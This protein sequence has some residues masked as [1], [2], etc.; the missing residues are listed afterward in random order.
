M[1][2]LPQEIYNEIGACFADAEENPRYVLSSPRPALATI[3]R[4]WQQAIEKQTFR[5]LRLRST[6]LDRFE[7]TVTGSRRRFLSGIRFVIILP[8]YPAE[9]RGR[10]ER[11]EERDA[12]D[13]AFTDAVNGLFRILKS[14]DEGKDGLDSGYSIQLDIEAVYS[15]TDDFHNGHNGCRGTPRRI[16]RIDVAELENDDEIRRRDLQ[17]RRFQ[18]SYI[19]LLGPAELPVVRA[20]SGFNTTVIKRRLAHRTAVDIAAKLPN[21]R[22]GNW[23]MDDSE[24]RYPAMR[25]SGRHQLAEV[26]RDV[27][28]AAEA[29]QTLHVCMSQDLLWNHAWLPADLT[30][31][32]K[33]A[34]GQE[35]S[36]QGSFDPLGCAIR[37]ATADL[38]S[39]KNLTVTGCLDESLL[40]PSPSSGPRL[41]EPF[42]QRLQRLDVQFNMTTPS[43]GW[44]FCARRPGDNIEPPLAARST[45]LLPPGHGYSEDEDTVAA[46]RYSDSENQRLSGASM[47]LFRWVPDEESLVPLVEAFGRA[48][49]QMPSLKVASLMTMIHVSLEVGAGRQVPTR[50][51]WGVSYA[52]PGEV[53]PQQFQLDPA[54]RENGGQRRVLWDV[55]DWQPP[56]HLRSILGDIGR[57][58]YG[59][60]LSEKHVDF[61]AAVMKPREL[62]R[63]RC[64]Y[65]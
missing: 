34:S 52:V 17:D 44:Y 19:R 61:W 55:K 46:L 33:E 60:E 37:E 38:G 10:F 11:K 59:D 7:K 64:S 27:L 24:Q 41:A 62:S 13:K 23:F 22:S 5:R 39:L 57:E 8:G 65:W 45:S 42:W 20:I 26:V 6:D 3:S 35:T 43:G 28:P 30:V 50:S 16:E 32:G 40:W 56:G 29:L 25:R 15:P 21:L 47:C 51:P 31:V 58:R 53:F 18:Y 14:W 4:P 54:Y 9:A 63:Y 48:C 49:S 2:R 12:N 36:G 1:D